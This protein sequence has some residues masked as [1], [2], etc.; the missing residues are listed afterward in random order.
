MPRKKSTKTATTKVAVSKKQ[1]VNKSTVSS[2][3]VENKTAKVEVRIL[4]PVFGKY[5]V[6]AEVGHIKKVHPNQAKEMI[7]NGDAEAV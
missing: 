4:N 2:S 6:V 3:V 1:S 7:E 5:Q